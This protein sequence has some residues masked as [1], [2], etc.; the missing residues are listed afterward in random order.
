M[1]D[2]LAAPTPPERR[3]PAGAPTPARRRVPWRKWLRA[4]HRD[5]GYLAVALTLAYGLSGIA[6]NHL[7]D[8]NPN[9]RFDDRA[10][11]VGPLPAGDLPAMQAHVVA[12]L[13]LDPRA[14]RGHFEDR[15]GDFRVFLGDGQEVRVDVATGRG[16][17]K[18]LARRRVFFEVN[19][20]HLNQLKGLWTWIA[21]GF[22]VALIVLALTGLAMNKGARGLAGRGKY[23]VGAGLAVP[24]V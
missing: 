16:V 14:V 10:V 13:A 22:A 7:D 1:A 12:A 8:W 6:V 20:L 11:D 4:V 3:S 19:A 24:I 9:Y 21:D 18:Q 23:F 15:P 5:L 2:D 17:H